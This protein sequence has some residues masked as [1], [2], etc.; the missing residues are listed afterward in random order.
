MSLPLLLVRLI[1]A[2]IYGY[3]DSAD[4]S[5]LSGSFTIMLCMALLEEIAMVLIYEG[6]GLTLRK[7]GKQGVATGERLDSFRGAS[8]DPTA[9]L[10]R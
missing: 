2:S 10:T 7:V 9:T 6:A 5:S 8:A 1:Y 3:R 4:F